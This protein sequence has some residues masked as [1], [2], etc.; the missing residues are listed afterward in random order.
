M[1]DEKTRYSESIY[2]DQYETITDVI[3][4]KEPAD[5]KY[6]NFVKPGKMTEKN[7]YINVRNEAGDLNLS[8]AMSQLGVK[9]DGKLLTYDLYND[10]KYAKTTT[11]SVD[12]MTSTTVF[13]LGDSV[14]LS[15]KIKLSNGSY[16]ISYSVENTGTK[17]HTVDVRLAFD[18]MNTPVITSKGHGSGIRSYYGA[19]QNRLEVTYDNNMNYAENLQNAESKL[20]DTDMATEVMDNS[21]FSI[22]EQAAQSMLAQANKDSQSVLSLLQG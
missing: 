15:Q 1:Y 20:R 2:E 11:S 22:L 16:Q 19:M 9:M 5:S 3:Y 7:G 8:C 12:E 10:S 13:E 21:K 18:T 17:A 4:T 6:T 14:K